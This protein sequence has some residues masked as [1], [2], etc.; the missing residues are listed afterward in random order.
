[1]QEQRDDLHRAI[2]AGNAVKVRERLEMSGDG[3]RLLALGKNSTGRC[4]LHLAVLRE[5]EDIVRYIAKNHPETLRVG[6]NVSQS[7]FFI[8]LKK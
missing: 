3:A 1:M 4:S 5:H 8:I 7:F 6:D 2:R